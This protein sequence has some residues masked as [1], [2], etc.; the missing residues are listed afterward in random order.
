MS[1]AMMNLPAS[2]DIDPLAPHRP[3][4]Y[5]DQL[6]DVVR[7]DAGDD[8][9]GAPAPIVRTEHFRLRRR[10]HRMEVEH[11]LRPDQLDNELTGLI[12]TELFSPGW[13]SGQDVFERV[14]TGVVRSCVNEPLPAWITF[15]T[16]TLRRIRAC[17]H[18]PDVT[19]E[20]PGP[21][22]PA[23]ADRSDV[24][25]PQDTGTSHSTIAGFAPVYRRALRLVSPG[26]TLDVGS[27][28][29]FLPLL[30]AQRQLSTVIASDLASGCT[31]LL[32]SVA[33]AFNVRLDTVTCDA[34]RV[35]LADRSVDT[36]TVIHLLE[37]LDPDH[38]RA[39]VREAMRLARRRVVVAVPFEDEPTAAYG[40]VRRFDLDELVR[41]GNHT[42]RPYTVD[43]Y[44]GGWLVINTADTAA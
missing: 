1:D 25:V 4:R 15:Y 7:E 41:L 44:H 34:A 42:G 5:T 6:L 27:C 19:G 8:R 24:G 39:V 11:R 43:E 9:G 23:D 13:L 35:P 14:F 21:D 33:E 22:F 29:G 38:G 40:H 26:A 36:V 12:A 28:F 37:H 31:R 30:I 3:G 10:G 2:R 32:D 18:S 20:T 16:N 17:W